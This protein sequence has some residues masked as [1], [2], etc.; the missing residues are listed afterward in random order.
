MI[1]IGL[2]IAALV[3]FILAALNWPS[4]TPFNLVAAGLACWVAS[5]LVSHF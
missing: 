5:L 1:V 2:L 3:L 4:T